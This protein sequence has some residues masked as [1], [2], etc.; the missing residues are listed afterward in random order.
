[1]HTHPSICIL[2]LVLLQG[3]LPFDI[4]NFPTLESNFLILSEAGGRIYEL[5]VCM[6]VCMYICMYVCMYVC[7][8]VCM[9]VCMYVCMNSCMCVCVMLESN[10]LIL[11]EAGGCIYELYVCMCVCMYVCVCVYVYVSF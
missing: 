2:R 8:C 7:V 3:L 9:Y 1:M 11:S 5:Y 10:F 6:Y 4:L